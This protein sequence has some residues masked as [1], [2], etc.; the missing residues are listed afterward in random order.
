MVR[1]DISTPPAS[2]PTTLLALPLPWLKPCDHPVLHTWAGVKSPPWDG[3][4]DVNRQKVSS[5]AMCSSW[6]QEA[7][8][9]PRPDHLWPDVLVR[10]H[11]AATDPCLCPDMKESNW[12]SSSTKFAHIWQ[13]SHSKD[14][15]SCQSTPA[16]ILHGKIPSALCWE[17]ISRARHE[18]L[19]IAKMTEEGTDGEQI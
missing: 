4:A 5:K 10:G 11:G 1:N 8:P 19:T 18:Q 2:T 9:K 13:T 12:K 7:S 3:A 6:V 17:A 14:T 15:V 16:L